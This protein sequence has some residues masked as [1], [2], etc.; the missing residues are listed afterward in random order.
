MH[1]LE[2]VTLAGLAGLAGCT[3]DGG[4]GGPGLNYSAY[5]DV[6]ITFATSSLYTEPWNDL[7]SRFTDET[8]I[9]VKVT[10]SR[11]SRRSRC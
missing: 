9:D 6:S 3:G 8:G 2:T 10:A 11:S 7:A 4:D 5:Q 1:Y